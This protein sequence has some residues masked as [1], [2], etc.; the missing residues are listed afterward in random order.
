[1]FWA[2]RSVAPAAH[3]PVGSKLPVFTAQ[4]SDGTSYTLSTGPQQV[5]VLSFWASYC[6]PCRAEAP[7]LSAAQ[8]RDIRVL[9]LSVESM[10]LSD[11]GLHARA[12][13][14]RFP[15]GSADDELVRRFQIGAVPTTYVIAP[16]GV[17]VLSRVGAISSSE[18]ETALASARRRAG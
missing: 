15:V 3:F 14:M 13:G 9:G 5:V 8:A 12:L 11:I 10:P 7:L 17:I 4:L 6:A 2:A 1:V 16:D 18:L